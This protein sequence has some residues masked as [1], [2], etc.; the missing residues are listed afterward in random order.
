MLTKQCGAVAKA[1]QPVGLTKTRFLV[2]KKLTS[3]SV[4]T[5]QCGAVANSIKPVGLTETRLLVPIKLTFPC[6]RR[7]MLYAG[8]LLA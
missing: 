4:L 2:P 7:E 1:I 8:C 6:P 5:K 3:P